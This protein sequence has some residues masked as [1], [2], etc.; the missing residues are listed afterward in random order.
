M[1]ESAA[2][3]LMEKG[4]AGGVGASGLNALCIDLGT[5]W[6][7]AHLREGE[8]VASGEEI[9]PP[10]SKPL[11]VRWICF[12][13]WLAEKL[14]T[15]RV[16]AVIFEVPFGRYVNVLKIQFGQATIIELMCETADLEYTGVR[17]Q[18]MKSFATGKGNASKGDMK[19]ALFERWDEFGID[20]PQADIGE[21]E[22]DAIWL[23]LYAAAELAV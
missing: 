18:E 21:N 17:P 2:S 7:W 14:Y 8:L 1:T 23:A 22:V 6:G 16:D 12:E 3:A 11:G 5:H 9:L 4:G 15:L 10:S 20:A 13:D 19:Q